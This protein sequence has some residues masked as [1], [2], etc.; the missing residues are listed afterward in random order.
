MLSERLLGFLREYYKAVRPSGN[1][2]FPGQDPDRPISASAVRSVF[3]Q[4]VAKAG[5]EKHI[6]FHCLRHS[7]AIHLHEAGADIRLIQS[8]LGHSSIRTTARYTHISMDQ[9]AKTRSPF[10]MMAQPVP[11][12]GGDHAA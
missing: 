5:I 7:F 3:N 1:Y 8:L 6:T 12:Q 2:L 9:T 4:A 11:A 10:D